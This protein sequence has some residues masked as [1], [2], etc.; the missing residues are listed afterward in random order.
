[1]KAG[2]KCENERFELYSKRASKAALL[3]LRA[4]LRCRA[5]L[6]GATFADGVLRYNGTNEKPLPLGEV[7][8]KP[9]ERAR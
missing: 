4:V 5:T 3:A 9:T 6:V 8:A 2:A 1:M 7:A